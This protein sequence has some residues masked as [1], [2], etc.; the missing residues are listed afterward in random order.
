[1][2]KS[3]YK[4]LFYLLKSLVYIK[5]ALF[6][7]LDYVWLFITK[8]SELFKNTIGFRIYKLWFHVQKWT[9]RFHIP[10][11]SR[12]I[13]LLG[14]RSTLQIVLFIV[15]VAI[16]IPHSKLYTRKSTEI[17]GQQTLLYQLVG[18]GY[19]DFALEEISV[20][21]AVLAPQETESW[22]QGA[23]T[24]QPGTTGNSQ[25][26]PQEQEISSISAG[27][28]AVTKPSIL[29][30][31]TLPSTSGPTGRTEIVYHTVKTGEI[32][33]TIAEKYSISVATILWAN[34]LSIRSYIR[35]GDELKILPVSGLVHKVKRGD[36]ISKL[37][38]TYSTSA[39][40]IIKSNKLKDDGSDIVIGEEL[41]VP[42]GAKPAP[43]YTYTPPTRQ[44]SQ[45]SSISAPPPSAGAPAG[46]GYL[47]PTDAKR[48]TQ[49]YGWRHT[50]LDIGG[51][52]GTAVYASKAGKVTRSQCGWNSG[53]GCYLIID[54]GGGVQTVYAHNSRLYVKVNESVVQGQTI[55]AMGST[56]RST[57]PHI[58]FEV[59]VNGRRMNPL[60]YIR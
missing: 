29:P 24:A 50:G 27:G 17:P 23:V 18:P 53:Y 15:I 59:R 30:G 34:N 28:T 58:H 32:I 19:Q 38:K 41:L 36:T 1:M 21:L 42:G 10:W 11:D 25:L 48:I 44:Y 9:G 13:E 56:G 14:K 49:Y 8:I 51:P 6:W 39:E 40:K 5:R 60:K 45:L 16:M 26:V 57:G 31:A 22:K 37:A 33:G 12:M 55:A 7:I 3:G 2:K 54:H 20:D 43:K 47:W 35:P 52:V 4:I 46:S